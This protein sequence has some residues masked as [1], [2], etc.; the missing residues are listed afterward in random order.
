MCSSMSFQIKCI[1]ETFA[2][3]GT[4]VSFSVTVT[5]HMPVKQPLQSENFG[6]ESALE[7]GRIRLWPCRG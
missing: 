7:F 5:L 3:E 4:K 1:I 2:T 6:A